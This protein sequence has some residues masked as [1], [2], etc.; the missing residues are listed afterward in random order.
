[1]PHEFLLDYLYPLVPHIKRMFGMHA[2]Y[3]GPKIY[4][5]TRDN[6]KNPLDNGIWIATDVVHHESLKTQFPSLINMT[7]YKI[8]K[9]LVLPIEASDFEEVAIEICELI[10]SG[11]S[12]IGVLPKPKKKKKKN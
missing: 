12:R 3:V 5:V 7:V 6:E 10:K 2:V 4:L 11:D 8:K 1:M 9:W